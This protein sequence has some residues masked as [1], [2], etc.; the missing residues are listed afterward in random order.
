MLVACLFRGCDMLATWLLQVRN[1]MQ[2][3][4]LNTL[5]EPIVREVASGEIEIAH[6]YDDVTVVQADMVGF[7]PL[8]ASHSAA[9]VLGIL[10]ELFDQF[11]VLATQYGVH[12]VRHKRRGHTRRIA[13]YDLPL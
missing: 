12:K 10:G 5:P 1:D 11:D 2:R 7:T 6:R 4:L 3:L 9:E 13:H 8:S